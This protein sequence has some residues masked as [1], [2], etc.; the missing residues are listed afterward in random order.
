[1]DQ[2]LTVTMEMQEYQKMKEAITDLEIAVSTQEQILYTTNILAE[3]IRV[4]EYTEDFEMYL[5]E[6][7]KP[8]YGAACQ[9][10]QEIMEFVRGYE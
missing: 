9:Q 5:L 4:K 2:Q 6:K 1:M 8:T 10:A 7:I 3:Y